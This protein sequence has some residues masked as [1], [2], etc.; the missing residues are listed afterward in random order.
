MQWVRLDSQA[1]SHPKLL[2]AGAE[3][4]ALWAAGL[5]HCNTHATNGRID[6]DM[7]PLLYPPLGPSKAKRAAEQLCRVGLWHDRG[8]HFEV[9]DYED[10]QAEAS[11]EAVEAKR[12]YERI[13][14]RE[15]RSKGRRPSGVPG[16]VPDNVPVDVPDS[17]PD[18][19]RDCPGLSPRARTRGRAPASDRPTDRSDRPVG[20]ANP[21]PPT[22]SLNKFTFLSGEPESLPAR[23]LWALWLELSGGDPGSSPT[24]L[25]KAA[26][27]GAWTKLA[28]RAPSEPEALWRRMVSAYCTDKRARD[29]RLDL[30]FLCAD[31]DSWAEFVARATPSNGVRPEQM[32][33]DF[34][35]VK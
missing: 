20:T 24:K 30:G 5:C 4:V 32:P 11:K 23:K 8:D 14:K 9:H 35:D 33:Y 27:E 12:E 3:G 2:R 6:L 29:Q 17:V 16:H 28:S 22:E 31:F 1:L 13:K 21:H 25:H 10:F 34:G 15:Q 18:T 26:L 19:V 7:V